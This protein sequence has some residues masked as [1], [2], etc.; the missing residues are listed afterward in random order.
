MNSLILTH[1]TIIFTSKSSLSEL[2]H[3]LV[4][5]CSHHNFCLGQRSCSYRVSFQENSLQMFGHLLFTLPRQFQCF[6]QL[7]K[8]LVRLVELNIYISAY[9]HISPCKIKYI[10]ITILAKEPN[11]Q[12]IRKEKVF[13]NQFQG[14]Y[15]CWY[16]RN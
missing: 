4:Y 3:V 10:C 2:C 16:V 8:H 1:E 13:I 14:I 5:L 7:N 6:K 12:S 9:I 11:L 15:Y